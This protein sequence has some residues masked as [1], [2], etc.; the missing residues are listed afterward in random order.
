MTYRITANFS[1]KQGLQAEFHSSRTFLTLAGAVA[2]IGNIES[3]HP[4]TFRYRF[5]LSIEQKRAAGVW[6]PVPATEWRDR[7]DAIHTSTTTRLRKHR[8]KQ[9]G[10]RLLKPSKPEV[11]SR[12]ASGRGDLVHR[13][14]DE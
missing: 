3:S 5:E 4:A 12:P 8:E 2:F 10:L 6:V 11:D 1:L 13:Q 14:R 9:N 7:V